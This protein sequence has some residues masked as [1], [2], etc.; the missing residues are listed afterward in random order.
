M[1]TRDIVKLR[2]F[3]RMKYVDK[4]WVRTQAPLAQPQGAAGTQPA[5]ARGSL[6]IS[7]NSASAAP[8]SAREFSV[9]ISSP[10]SLDLLDDGPAHPPAHTAAAPFDLFGAPPSAATS[11]SHSFDALSAP[12][13]SSNTSAFSSSQHASTSSSAGADLFSGFSA[14]VPATPHVPVP[15]PPVAVAAPPRK[16]F[17]VFDELTPVPPPPNPFSPAQPGYRYPPQQGYGVPQYG[18]PGYAQQGYPVQ[19]GYPQAGFSAQQGPQFAHPGPGQYPQPYPQPQG[20]LY[21]QPPGYPAGGSFPPH[22]G[23]AAPQQISPGPYPQPTQTGQVNPFA[24]PLPSNPPPADPFSAMGNIAWS[25]VT[26]PVAGPGPAT[27]PLPSPR[28]AEH[29]Q[30]ESVNPF[31]LF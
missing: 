3:I 12:A 16:D 25:G 7:I 22:Q 10:P 15:V 18:G 8:S 24:S 14:P 4:R 28:A 17:S 23:P 19:Q 20:G 30:P 13:P 21:S 5:P 1:H 27:N 9:R 29:K 11:V 6:N 2:E 26:Q 31:D